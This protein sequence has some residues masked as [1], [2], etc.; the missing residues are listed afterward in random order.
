MEDYNYDINKIK[1]LLSLEHE[2]T[3]TYFNQ[4][5]FSDFFIHARLLI[6]Y[7]LKFIIF[8]VLNNEEFA[9]SYIK[10]EKSIKKDSLTNTYIASS[11]PQR[12]EPKG[13]FFAKLAKYAFY[14]RHPD[15][16]NTVDI[17]KKSIGKNFASD[18]DNLAN[19]YRVS[20]ELEM[21]T[22]YSPLDTIIQAKSLATFFEKCIDDIKSICIETK[23]IWDTFGKYDLSSAETKIISIENELNRLYNETSHFGIEGGN[24]FIFLL[25]DSI[26]K[27]DA[28]LLDYLFNI[29]CAL[30]ADFGSNSVN[31]VSSSI[32]SA[33]WKS[34]VHVLKGKD[35]FIVGSSM[36]N[37]LFCHG[38]KNLGDQITCGFKNWKV[39]R[40]KTLKEILTNLVKKNNSCHFYVMNFLNQPNYAPHIFNML[41]DVFG[42]EIYAKNRC[43]FFTFS[44]D[45]ETI[46]DIKRWA[47]YTIVNHI[48]L[49]IEFLDFLSFINKKVK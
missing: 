28:K 43:D 27:I 38:N 32:N 7:T 39:S 20:S 10:G 40:S 18:M 3:V 17:T 35:D 24:R 29:P 21:H 25:P 46:C 30:V 48:E 22:N 6:E 42:E 26:G 14:F 5:N 44:K 8:D 37:W 49:N 45:K 1:E 47:E 16:L 4:G 33:T 2:S 41:I 9:S 13:V 19:Y 15:Y 36:I 12:E 11:D 23:K 31:D 34:K